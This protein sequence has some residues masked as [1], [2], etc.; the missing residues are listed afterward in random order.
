MH[1]LHRGLDRRFL[2]RQTADTKQAVVTSSDSSLCGVDGEDQ[3]AGWRIGWLE[4]T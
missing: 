3:F 2:S 4:G 1:A